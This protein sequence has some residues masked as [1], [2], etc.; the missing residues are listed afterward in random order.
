MSVLPQTKLSAEEFIAWA[1]GRPERFELVDGE[2]FAQAAERA[3]HAEVKGA[4]YVALLGAIQR[5]GLPCRALPDGM[6]VRVDKGTVFE[7]DA[8]VYCGP[9]MAPSELLVQNPII[10]VEVLSPSTGRND[11]LGKLEGYFRLASVRHYLIV[12]PD[13]PLVIHHARGQG[14]DILTHIIREG[15]VRLDPPGLTVSLSDIYVEGDR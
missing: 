7:P 1:E 8:Q 12:D 11:A 14:A 9:R 13:Q 5:H 4:V 6:A 15:E 10:V 3:A 2:V